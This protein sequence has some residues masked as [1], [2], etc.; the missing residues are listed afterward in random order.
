MILSY[1]LTP[2]ILVGFNAV[3]CRSLMNEGLFC[4]RHIYTFS[5]IMKA[6]NL[7]CSLISQESYRAFDFVKDKVMKDELN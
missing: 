2:V 5:V 1:C 4:C 3:W 7:L 6:Q